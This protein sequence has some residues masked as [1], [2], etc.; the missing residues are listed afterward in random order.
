MT[1][2]LP[3]DSITFIIRNFCDSFGRCPLVLSSGHFS[4]VDVTSIC[5][6]EKFFK[7]SFNSMYG[8]GGNVLQFMKRYGSLGAKR[9]DAAFM[10]ALTSSKL[11]YVCI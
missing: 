6:P 10:K 8:F 9:I 2:I 7:W 3:A 1:K 5:T 11:R 4:P